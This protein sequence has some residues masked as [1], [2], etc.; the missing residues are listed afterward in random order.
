MNMRLERPAMAGAWGPVIWR[1]GQF[2][3]SELGTTEGI[4]VKGWLECKQEGGGREEEMIAFLTTMC[5]I[6]SMPL[7]YTNSLNPRGTNS[8]RSVSMV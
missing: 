1:A 6:V 8:H 7:T 5:Q 4:K 2:R 3:L